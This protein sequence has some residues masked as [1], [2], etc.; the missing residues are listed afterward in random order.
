MRFNSI[1]FILHSSKS[2]FFFLDGMFSWLSSELMQMRHQD[3]S[4]LLG[5]LCTFACMWCAYESNIYFLLFQ[6]IREN[7]SSRISLELLQGDAE[8]YCSIMKV[9]KCKICQECLLHNSYTI[10][11]HLRK[12]HKIGPVSLENQIYRYDYVALKEPKKKES[13]VFDATYLQRCFVT[14]RMSKYVQH[15]KDST[16]R[17]SVPCVVKKD[18]GKGTLRHFGHYGSNLP[19]KPTTEIGDLCVF[20]C[21]KCDKKFRNSGKLTAHLSKVCFPK[22]MKKSIAKLVTVCIIEARY[23]FCRMCRHVSFCDM[24]IIENH[25]RSHHQESLVK[26]MFKT[27]I[28]GLRSKLLL[29]SHYNFKGPVL[30]ERERREV[31]SESIT[32]EVENLCTFQ[33]DQCYKEC[34]SL[35]FLKSHLLKCKG[36]G[37]FQPDYVTSAVIHECKLCGTRLL[38]DK[39]VICRHLF[40]AHSLPLKAYTDMQSITGKT[41]SKAEKRIKRNQLKFSSRSSEDVLSV[42]LVP[43][44]KGIWNAKNSLPNTLTTSKVGNYCVYSCDICDFKSD[45][46]G[47]MK[48]HNVNSDHGPGHSKYNMKY[49]TEARY[50]RCAICLKVMLCDISVIK[51]HVKYSHGCN[52]A[53]YLDFVMGVEVKIE[54]LK[55]TKGNIDKKS[56]QIKQARKTITSKTPANLLTLECDKCKTVLRSWT[57]MAIHVRKCKNESGFREK[58]VTSTALHECKLC[59]KS[60]LCDKL[61][62]NRHTLGCHKITAKAYAA[63]CNNDVVSPPKIKAV[64]FKECVNEKSVKVFSSNKPECFRDY[65]I[66][67]G[68]IKDSDMTSI[69]SNLCIFK[70]IYCRSKAR[71]WPDMTVHINS[72]HPSDVARIHFHR[73]FIHKSVYHKCY[74]CLRGVL[75]D[76]ELIKRHIRKAHNIFCL[77]KYKK[78]GEKSGDE[79]NDNTTSPNSHYEKSY[80][81]LP[82]HISHDMVCDVSGNDCLFCCD[83]CSRTFK[84]WCDF[85][86]HKR[87]VHDDFRFVFEAAF[88][89]KAKYYS[90]PI[91]KLFILCDR[92]ILRNHLS[93]HNFRSLKKF[94]AWLEKSKSRGTSD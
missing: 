27:T 79:E 40:Q 81:D 82:S 90:C 28:E 56:S 74:I 25:V 15:F 38:C 85:R 75:C 39:E 30:S 34:S 92:Y 60:L 65:A 58:Y 23:H 83:K 10:S 43:P 93:C 62:I 44:L 16:N 1:P 29:I 53:K 31:N 36:D 49:V 18:L 77:E 17:E 87:K 76:E 72:T 41:N 64:H 19:V 66:P 73:D 57:L 69:I 86:F 11:S 12:R 91:C 7:H 51:P 5:D 2:F 8:S 50:H 70:C 71:R 37:K 52:I 33:C 55:K 89:R 68:L 4:A 46:W 47:G 78:L 84:S 20:Q 26:Y 80:T 45:S 94:D 42:P 88:V 24:T 63:L 21:Q 35:L 14:M 9:T 61:L 13:A 67:N 48:N 54:L 6:H 59:G 32:R 3:F 22:Y